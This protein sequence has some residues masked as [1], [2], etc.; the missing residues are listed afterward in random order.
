[1]P[2][3]YVPY[4]TFRY[5]ILHDDLRQICDVIG[6]FG[7]VRHVR[8]ARAFRH[9]PRHGTSMRCQRN[10]THARC[11]W[12]FFFLLR[13]TTIFPASG[14]LC[15]RRTHDRMNLGSFCKRTL[16]NLRLRICI[17]YVTWD[18]W[19]L[20]GTRASVKSAAHFRWICKTCFS[21]S[22]RLEDARLSIKVSSLRLRFHLET[23][24]GCREIVS[25]DLSHFIFVQL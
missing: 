22:P 17:L 14:R 2:K 21:F 9:V 1:M 13:H 6:R 25:L 20:I 12:R 18:L 23:Q 8:L 4:T 7:T 10:Q 11:L 16:V 3:S 24:W 15:L 19:S 5:T